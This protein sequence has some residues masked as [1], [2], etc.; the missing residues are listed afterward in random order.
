MRRLLRAN[1]TR[2]LKTKVFW[3]GMVS[4][5]LF[6]EWL[7]FDIYLRSKRYTLPLDEQFGECLFQSCVLIGILIAVCS[8]LF[9]GTEY[10]EGTIRNKLMIGQPRASIYLSGWVSC[11][12]ASITQAAAAILAVLA[13]GGLLVGAPKIEA[14]S[15][16]KTF[17]VLVFL[18]VSYVSVF[19][20]FSM[21]VTSKSHAA[22]V[23]VLLAFMLLVA[24]SVMSQMLKAPEM[25]NDYIMNA[26]GSIWE[27]T[28]LMPNPNYITGTK[29]IIYQFLFD[30]LPGG[31]NLQLANAAEQ[32]E[33]N[34]VLLCVYS[35]VISIGT[36]G[37]GI[38]LFQRKDIK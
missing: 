19:H 11:L 26:D 35:A 20:M 15:F 21:L 4:L 5:A 13:V 38:F 24:A 16:F 36:N 2:M 3:G 14:G 9:T 32:K 8:S 30:F 10:D 6:G 34:A 37:I 1:I 25:V 7:F 28:G 12:A 33:M 23:N 31:Q 18:C 29:R 27:K 17:V 22:M